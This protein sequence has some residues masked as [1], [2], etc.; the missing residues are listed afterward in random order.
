M[1]FNKILLIAILAGY[2]EK[3]LAPSSN[4]NF[5]SAFADIWT[6]VGRNLIQ[7][8]K[9]SKLDD[10]TFQLDFLEIVNSLSSGTFQKPRISNKLQ[11]GIKSLKKEHSID[12]IKKNIFYQFLEQPY[13]NILMNNFDMR[14]SNAENDVPEDFKNEYFK[15]LLVGWA[16]RNL[17]EPESTDQKKFDNLSKINAKNIE[18]LGGN[19]NYLVGD[20]SCDPKNESLYQGCKVCDQ[21]GDKTEEYYLCAIGYNWRLPLVWDD[22]RGG[23]FIDFCYGYNLITLINTLQ[24]QFRLKDDNY[25]QLWSKGCK[26]D[27]SDDPNGIKEI[28][29]LLTAAV[30]NNRLDSNIAEIK[31]D[32]F[33]RPLL[34]DF[35][36]S[37]T[38][39]LKK[40]LSI[41][42]CAMIMDMT[43]ANF[44]CYRT[45]N[46]IRKPDATESQK[47]QK[48]WEDTRYR[49]THSFPYTFFRH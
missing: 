4:I 38:E 43:G 36:Q 12:D 10:N 23:Q 9:F 6:N 46:L 24:S 30:G 31:F 16:E 37:H 29:R 5:G 28:Y 47:M 1:N 19:F 7:R 32:E 34:N 14:L 22:N 18:N 3:I 27:Y 40:L 26:G 35:P 20:P 8:N 13:Y 21:Y 33:K 11:E 44:N 17:N 45:T 15:P 42:F 39:Y 25:C 49:I 48:E 41:C 2:A